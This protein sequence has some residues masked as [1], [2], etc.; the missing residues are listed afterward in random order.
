MPAQKKDVERVER[1]LKG[2]LHNNAASS[3]STKSNQ[4]Q[5]RRYVA[6]TAGREHLQRNSPFKNRSTVREALG[7]VLGQ[8][9]PYSNYG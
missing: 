7:R 5:A 2:L 4:F 3:S 6:M 1:A 9:N 8:D